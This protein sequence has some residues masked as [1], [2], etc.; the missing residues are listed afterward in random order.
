MTPRPA[1]PLICLEQIHIL[2]TRAVWIM[3]IAAMLA[4]VTLAAATAPERWQA[5]AHAEQMQ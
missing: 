5:A 1:I 3:A 4:A 2:R